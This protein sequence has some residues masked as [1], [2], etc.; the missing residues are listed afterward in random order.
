MFNVLPRS[1]SAFDTT[2]EKQIA[3][4]R[5]MVDLTAVPAP[6][7]GFLGTLFGAFVSPVFVEIVKNRTASRNSRVT[8]EAAEVAAR[9]AMQQALQDG[10]ADLLRIQREALD[11]FQE[12]V[13]ELTT[14]VEEQSQ[15]IEEMSNHIVSLES[16]IRKLGGVVPPRK[17]TKTEPAVA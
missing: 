8:V 10:F 6:M 13:K 11:S 2:T 9:P 17:R 3:G 4:D 16:E 14:R 1:N 15:Q 12:Q 5:K 7:W